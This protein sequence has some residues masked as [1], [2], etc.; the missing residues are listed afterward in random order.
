MLRT[1]VTASPRQRQLQRRDRHLEAALA[2]WWRRLGVRLGDC[3]VGGRL[4][5]ASLDKVNC[6]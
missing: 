6:R 4:V 1:C 5:Q 2:I 3:Q